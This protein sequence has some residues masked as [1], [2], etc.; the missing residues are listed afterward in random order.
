MCIYIYKYKYTARFPGPP[1]LHDFPSEGKYRKN[2]E[3][4]KLRLSVR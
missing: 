1:N 2:T 3:K 4:I